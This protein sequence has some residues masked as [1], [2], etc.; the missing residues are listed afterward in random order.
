MFQEEPTKFWRI[1]VLQITEAS[2][3]ES[4]SLRIFLQRKNT[5][6][7]LSGGERNGWIYFVARSGTY[8]LQKLCCLIQT[9]R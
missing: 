4:F 1:Q 3:G 6:R 5:K 7:K 9:T 2:F 8:L